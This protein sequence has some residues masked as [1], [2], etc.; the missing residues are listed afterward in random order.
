MEIPSLLVELHLQ[1]VPETAGNT[2]LYIDIIWIICFVF[3]FVEFLV[4]T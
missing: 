3:V 1:N 2:Y 4:V